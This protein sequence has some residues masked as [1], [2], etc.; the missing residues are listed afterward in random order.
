MDRPVSKATFPEF[1]GDELPGDRAL[2][3]GAERLQRAVSELPLRYAPFFGQLSSLWAVPEARVRSELTRAKNPR[4]WSRTLLRGL[5]T[6]DIDVSGDGAEPGQ[7]A[8]L[9]RFEPGARL[10]KHQHRGREQ[11][12]V[13]EGAYVDGTGLE[14]HAGQ[15]QSMAEGSE[16]ELYI[17]GGAP[18]VAAVSERGIAFSGPWLRW[19]N[20][21][22][23]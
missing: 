11:V 19:V 10:P 16:H 18:C 21:L 3:L 4:S 17:I 7:R 12:L 22:L 2:R 5:R 13:L 9:M 15:E 20:P 8:R 6:F 23:R 14:V 1:S